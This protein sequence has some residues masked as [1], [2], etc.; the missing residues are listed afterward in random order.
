MTI[1]RTC[2]EDGATISSVE[3]QARLDATIHR[4]GRWIGLLGG[5]AYASDIPRQFITV[6]PP[7]VS[8]ALM[9]FA[10]SLAAGYIGLAIGAS[11]R[12]SSSRLRVFAGL[13]FSA[14]GLHAIATLHATGDPTRFGAVAILIFLSSFVLTT[15][16]PFVVLI[17]ITLAGTLPVVSRFNPHDEFDTFATMLV[18][19][20]AGLLILVLR[21]HRLMRLERLKWQEQRLGERLQG[22][23]V[24]LEREISERIKSDR[25]YRS[26]FDNSIVGVFQCTADG[27]FTLANVTMARMLGYESISA[28]LAA[29]FVDHDPRDHSGRPLL[30]LSRAAD[31]V[32]TARG[33][34]ERRRTRP[35]PP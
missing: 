6:R 8:Y 7:L 34:A 3:L 15:I 32:S 24:D 29:S 18:A 17:A 25:R 21:R 12:K 10:A 26:I 33:W 9:V 30:S 22:T 31:G 23:E 27:R 14:S 11:R 28:L 20:A 35:Y 2:T 13:L 1:E 16:T 19:P 4:S 5:L